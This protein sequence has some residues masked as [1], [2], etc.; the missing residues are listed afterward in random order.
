MHGAGGGAPKGSGNGRFRH[1]LFS[2]EFVEAR[3]AIRML[4]RAARAER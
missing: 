3:A 1:G 2:A 4:G